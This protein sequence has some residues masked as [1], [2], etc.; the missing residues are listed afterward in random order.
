MKKKQLLR[1]KS[2][3]LDKELNALVITVVTELGKG[4]AEHSKNFN[5][6]LKLWEI[7]VTTEEYNNY[8]DNTRRKE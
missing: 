5:K 3:L 1:W 4:I 6:E 2:I 7:S 8:N